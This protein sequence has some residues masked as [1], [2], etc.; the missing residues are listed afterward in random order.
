MI[1]RQKRK[2]KLN[3]EINVVPYID[4]MMVLLVIFMVTAPMLTQGVDVQLPKASADPVD[5]KDSEPLIVTVDEQG[6]YYINIGSAEQ[7]AVTA[8]DVGERVQKVLA[9]NPEKMLLVKG[10]KRVEYDKVIGL[11]ALLQQAG[12][13]SVGLVTE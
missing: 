2:R 7:S 1:R 13:P 4:V 10:D 8:E 12:A 3:A 11:M 5:S 6:Q 9:A